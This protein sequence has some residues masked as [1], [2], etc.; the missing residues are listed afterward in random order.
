M[1]RM[2]V[3]QKTEI[4]VDELSLASL[5]WLLAKVRN[6]ARIWIFEPIGR[7]IGLVAGW[8][9]AIGWL[10]GE[11]RQI[12]V[13]IGH[14][15]D[16]A[17]ASPYR[18]LMQDIHRLCVEIWTEQLATDPVLKVVPV[19][20][21][22]GKLQLYFRKILEPAV[23][24]DCLRVA[25]AIWI[26]RSR[27][28]VAQDRG[29]LLVRRGVWSEN[30]QQYAVAAG[31]HME[32]YRWLLGLD[33]MARLL[34]RLARAARKRFPFIRHWAGWVL[35]GMHSRLRPLSGQGDA[36]VF[37]PMPRVGIRYG[38]RE[39]SL[40]PTERSEFFWLQSLDPQLPVLLYD[41][42]FSSP[43]EPGLMTDLKQRGIS[44]LG[45]APGLS[46]WLPT[47]EMV[48]EFV[49]VLV[50]IGGQ[51]LADPRK[52]SERRSYILRGLVALAWDVSYWHDF[53]KSNRILINV[54]AAN[55]TVGQTLALDALGGISIGYQYSASILGPTHLLSAG[56]N[57][58][59]VFS[60]LFQQV[61][62]EIDAPVDLYLHS[63]Y[64]YDV[65]PGL[66]RGLERVRERRER[67][68]ANGARFVLCYLDENS[69]DRWDW[70]S[71][72]RDAARDYEYLLQW[73]LADPTLG[74]IFKPKKSVD[75]RS[76]L[77]SIRDLIADAEQTG[78]CQ[79]IISKSL[80]GSTFPAE[81]ALSADLCI[82]KL[83]GTTAALEAAL[84]GSRSVLVDTEGFHFHPV[85][86][87]GLDRVVFEGWTDLRAAVE[88]FRSD[89]GGFPRFGD[90]TPGLR[91]FDPFLD[92]RGSQRMGTI[93]VSL[94]EALQSGVPR[95]EAIRRAYDRYTRQWGQRTPLTASSE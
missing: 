28:G 86:T 67:L 2:G 79:F 59:V 87:W 52:F 92:G 69:V 64:I 73:L 29:L 81:A 82:G 54:G 42:T 48:T 45:R 63:G 41:C 95:R 18:R 10:H 62:R 89:P 31:I 39:L 20:W 71:T 26:L 9:R 17:G 90:W 8:L 85:R 22:P 57:V 27:L 51:A 3:Q 36:A 74:I 61:W 30:T 23:R 11:M 19:S 49:K 75:L 78:R 13:H 70:F 34:A 65:Q 24:A 15:R 33:S 76:R 68:Q 93:I 58:Q 1:D 12:D 80:V 7:G 4:F 25:M 77:A 35:R 88:R 40:D 55:T 94:L 37:H 43:L 91:D 66:L 44:V 14:V 60:P 6:D 38:H 84:V 5:A 32:C 83:S 47:W 53:F 50:R 16:E 46:T 21:S 72:S 56:E